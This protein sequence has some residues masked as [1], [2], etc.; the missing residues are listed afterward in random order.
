GV[1]E[2]P[3]Y[4]GGE[5]P[6]PHRTRLPEDAWIRRTE[7]VE[8]RLD[9]APEIGEQRVHPRRR[10]ARLALPRRGLELR[11]GERLSAGVR[12]QPLGGPAHV[13]EVEAD[14]GG[15]ARARPQLL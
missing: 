9:P 10:L 2:E 14:R 4:G 15:P 6:P 3:P 12:E 13:P 5:P 8:R 11:R 7:R 1:E